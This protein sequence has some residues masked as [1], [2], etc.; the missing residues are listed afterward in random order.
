MAVGCWL[1]PTDRDRGRSNFSIGSRVG[2]VDRIFFPQAERRVGP[3]GGR[4]ATL[5]ILP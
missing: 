4:A 3:L 1:F 5:V 2:S